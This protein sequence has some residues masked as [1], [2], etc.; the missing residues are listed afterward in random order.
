MQKNACSN[1]Q[2]PKTT[3]ASRWLWESVRRERKRSKFMLNFLGKQE[4]KSSM[5]EG[6]AEVNGKVLK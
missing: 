4:A 5:N 1:N 6:R 3:S 2:E